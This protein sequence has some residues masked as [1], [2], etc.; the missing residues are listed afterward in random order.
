L[1]LLVNRLS[2]YSLF[3]QTKD[4]SSLLY[5][6]KST[7]TIQKTIEISYINTS[8]AWEGLK[9]GDLLNIEPEYLTFTSDDIEQYCEIPDSGRS[10]P[11]HDISYFSDTKARKKFSIFC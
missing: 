6:A 1:I 3:K 5:A 7:E 9:N 8:K 2:N 10:T 4:K 11:K